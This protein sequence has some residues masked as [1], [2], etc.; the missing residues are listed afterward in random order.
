MKHLLNNLSEEEKQSILE[1]HKGGMKV[2]SENF[3]RLIGHKSGTILNEQPKQ[4][5]GGTS[6][7][8]TVSQE[9]TI[10]G[11]E[12]INVDQTVQMFK[13]DRSK[14]ENR[15]HYIVTFYIDEVQTQGEYLAVTYDVP[16][17]GKTNVKKDYSC[18]SKAIF[19]SNEIDLVF[20][21][22][23]QKRFDEFCT[24]SMGVASKQKSGGTSGIA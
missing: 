3:K 11:R 15:G 21:P 19:D 12:T 14:P 6:T 10:G 13:Y 16:A 24:K 7:Q 22:I 1:Q 20:G 23:M 2:F 9:P 18:L 8:P 5:G 17:H 4:D